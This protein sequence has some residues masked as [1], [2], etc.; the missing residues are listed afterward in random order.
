M[1]GRLP[2]KQEVGGSSPPSP[3]YNGLVYIRIKH[4]AIYR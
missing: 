4:P 3:K 1:N 2:Y